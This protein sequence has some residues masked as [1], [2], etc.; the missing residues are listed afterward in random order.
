MMPLS[1]GEFRENCFTGHTVLYG[2][3]KMLPPLL[4][5]TFL[6]SVLGGKSRY[7]RCPQKFVE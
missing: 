1:A 2:V 6:R 7:K 3:D 5:F 4:F